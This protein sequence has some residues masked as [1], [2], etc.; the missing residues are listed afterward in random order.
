MKNTFLSYGGGVDSTA[1]LVM[2]ANKEIE[3]DGVVFCNVGDDSER[4]ATLRYVR[5]VAE[6]FAKAHDIPFIVLQRTKRDGTPETLYQRVMRPDARSVPIPVYMANGAPGN[7]TCT[8]D[9][10]IKLVN[11]YHRKHGATSRDPGVT[12]L[13][14]TFDQLHRMADSKVKYIVNSYPLAERGIK[15]IDCMNIIRRAGLVVPPKSSCWFCTYQRLSS[16]RE[17][18]DEAPALFSKACGMEQHANVIRQRIGKDA[19]WLTR[20]N[21]PLEKAVGDASQPSLFA[22]MIEDDAC[23]SGYCFV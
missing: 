13:G 6:P 18:R 1:L 4:P 19:V 7:R 11:A 21:K 15:R 2:A 20:Y 12:V 5:E 17:L 14:I 3:L 16:W 23:E 9:F 22:G 8:G 10:K